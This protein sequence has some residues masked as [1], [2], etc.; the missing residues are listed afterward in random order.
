MELEAI[1]A[2]VEEELPLVASNLGKVAE[3][4]LPQFADVIKQA[5]GSSGKG[6]RPALTLLAGKFNNFTLEYLIPMATAVELL[7]TASLVHDDTI[8]KSPLRRGLPT[9]YSTLG[10][11]AAIMAGDY[12]FAKSAELAALPG[13]L[14][15]VRLFARTLMA[16]AKGELEETLTL[17]DWHQN[18]RDYFRRIEGKTAALFSMAAESGA[19]L[20][21][22]H[23]SHIQALKDYGRSIGLAFQ[24]VDDLLDFTSDEETL[25]KPVGNDLLLGVL[26][27][28]SLIYLEQHPDGNPIKRGFEQ[29]GEGA[30]LE[31]AVE[32]IRGSTLIIQESFAIARGLVDDAKDAINILPENEFRQALMALADYVFERRK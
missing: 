4:D 7:H 11:N 12:L 6:V 21:E 17:Y 28:P 15:V 22:A 10:D 16:L 8:D 31:Q 30:E 1:L 5:L 32:E 20:S 13:N 14:R 24:V 26:T 25:G 19:I 27:L 3:V 2:P 18:R 29:K 9:L 23:E